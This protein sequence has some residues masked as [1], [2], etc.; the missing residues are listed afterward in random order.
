MSLEPEWLGEMFSAT[1]CPG[2]ALAFEATI[3]A[4][5]NIHFARSPKL[6]INAH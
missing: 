6:T 5:F 2:A 3:D 1:L 4:H